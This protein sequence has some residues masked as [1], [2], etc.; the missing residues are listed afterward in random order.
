MQKLLC[1]GVL[2]ILY[3]CGTVHTYP[4]PD[5][6][7]LAQDDVK[8]IPI[9]KA[10]AE[11]IAKNCPSGNFRINLGDLVA[12]QEGVVIRKIRCMPDRKIKKEG[13]T[14]T[15]AVFTAPMTAKEN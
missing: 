3:G 6:K 5:Y 14:T 13:T 11:W 2:F 10:N 8:P 9:T 4:L 12:T 15:T 7:Y 1:L